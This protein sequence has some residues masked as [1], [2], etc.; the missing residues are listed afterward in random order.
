[1]NH[2][3]MSSNRRLTSAIA[4][5]VAVV[6]LLVSASS[7][8]TL[9][10]AA[11]PQH[12]P[13]AEAA[14]TALVDAAKAGDKAALLAILG[15]TAQAL[16]TS[17]DEIA[18]REGRERFVR[19]YQEAH[20]LVSVGDG[21]VTLTVGERQWS[22]PIPIVKDAAG[23]W[24]DTAEGRE[25]ILNRRIGRNELSAI[26][27]CLV[28]V[29]AQRE[30]YVRDP[31]RDG[32]LEY[33]QRLGSTRDKRDGLY[34]ETQPSEAPSPLG[35]LFAKAQGEGYVAKGLGGRHEP[36]WGYY[37][38]ILKSQGEHA[39]GGAYDY[40]A[41]GHMIGGFGLIAYPAEYGSSGVVTFIVNHEGVVYQKD[42]GPNTATVARAMKKFDPDTT[43]K[44]Q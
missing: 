15:P 4:L 34:W 35:P 36:Y 2:S 22:L 31:D 38:R 8:T 16:V 17:G 6:L 11:K 14:A 5:A 30:Y 42:L 10:A 13:S 23:W 39:T 44:R 32:L 19:E 21:K 12:F 27:V 26:Q 18:D 9:A 25:E 1:M 7:V 33:A 24:F 29:D 41:K 43:W 28:Y 20:R 3:H 40:V 37:Y